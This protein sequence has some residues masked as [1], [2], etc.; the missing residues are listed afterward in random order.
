MILYFRLTSKLLNSLIKMAAK[1]GRQQKSLEAGSGTTVTIN[2][3][4]RPNADEVL[5]N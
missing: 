4:I 5:N 1:R 2:V 3:E